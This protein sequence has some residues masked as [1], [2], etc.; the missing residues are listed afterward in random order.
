MTDDRSES[1]E[2]RTCLTALLPYCLIAL[3]RYCSLPDCCPDAWAEVNDSGRIMAPSVRGTF[4]RRGGHD[5]DMGGFR[6]PADS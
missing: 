3:L 6:D 2:F 4:L 5:H 1:M